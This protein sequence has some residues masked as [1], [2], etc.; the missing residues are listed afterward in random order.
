MS[1]ADRTDGHDVLRVLLH[2]LTAEERDA[3]VLAIRRERDAEVARVQERR[4]AR[5]IGDG[6]S[7]PS[8]RTRLRA[9]EPRTD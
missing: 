7:R 8:P 4:G 1:R 3:T 6:R 9:A 2:G 5:R